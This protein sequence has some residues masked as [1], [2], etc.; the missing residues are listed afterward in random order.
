MNIFYVFEIAVYMIFDAFRNLAKEK[1]IIP[2]KNGLGIIYM[3]IDTACMIFGTR[4]SLAEVNAS[5]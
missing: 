5:L 4:K 2:T 1:K 3:L